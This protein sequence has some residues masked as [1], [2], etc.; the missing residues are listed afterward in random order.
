[1]V[2]DIYLTITHT[3]AAPGC[4]VNILNPVHRFAVFQVL[5]RRHW[6]LAPRPVLDIDTDVL[7]AIAL[8]LV[9]AGGAHAHQAGAGGEDR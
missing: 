4:G 2:L 5:R 8:N 1:M 3:L 7:F 9:T 6:G